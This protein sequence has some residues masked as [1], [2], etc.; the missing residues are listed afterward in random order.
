MAQEILVW[1]NGALQEHVSPDDALRILTAA[2]EARAAEEAGAKGGERGAT[3]ESA[4]APVQARSQALVWQDIEGDFQPY[5]A[6]LVRLYGLAP[7]TLSSLADEH[8]ITKLRE[9]R[10]YFHL[11]LHTVT[12]DPQTDTA[13]V[14]RLDILFGLALHRHA[15]QRPAA[16]ASGLARV[17]R[18]RQRRGERDEPGHALSALRAARFA[19]G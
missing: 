14:P 10:D 17:H 15:A 2:R 11:V 16:L 5:S 1:A 13:T 9:A 7:L 12:Y 6:E 8:A 4:N 19:G 18:G 3:A